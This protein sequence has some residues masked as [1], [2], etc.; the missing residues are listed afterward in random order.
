M[1]NLVKLGLIASVIA[2]FSFS[3][4]TDKT[5]EPPVDTTDSTALVATH[6]IA[7][8]KAMLDGD[9]KEITDS[10]IV[11]V[12]VSAND[13]SGNIYKTLYVQDASGAIELKLDATNLFNDYPVGTNLFI[14][15]KGMYLGDYHGVV[16]L[17]GEYNG[18]VGRLDGALIKYH[19]FKAGDEGEVSVK[20]VKI[21]D[22]TDADIDQIVKLS[23][24]QFASDDAG[25]TYSDA[26]ASA[27]RTLMD[28]LGNV[29]I[30]RS[31]N[32]ADFAQNVTPNG[33]GEITAVLGKYGTDYQLYIR[34]IN[35]VKFDNARWEDPNDT[36]A[37]FEEGFEV[38]DILG[39]FTAI[40][41]SGD[42]AW[43]QAIYS[44]NG[45]AKM[46]GFNDGANEDWLISPAIDINRESN[47]SF[48]TS[49]DY[50]DSTETTLSVFYSSNFDGTNLATATWTDITSNF[51]Y[52]TDKYA[53][54]ESGEYKFAASTG[55]VYIAFKYTCGTSNV[56]TWQIDDV[57]VK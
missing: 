33:M 57:L 9:L 54:V 39:Q 11:K 24:V 41:V 19:L 31:S 21:A 38:A 51:K 45:F 25:K 49:M 46:S 16:Q 48:R 35:E 5:V 43:H 23:N 55:K 20:E 27:N 37:I 30:V 44:N 12:T 34:D 22:I 26:S 40:S 32:Y 17:G 3:A 10:V 52:S 18:A 50:G 47:F 8:L 28:T 15:A 56:P 7:Q 53:W 36:L 29:I 14:S 42:N 1:K 6:T 4:C 13:K 2:I